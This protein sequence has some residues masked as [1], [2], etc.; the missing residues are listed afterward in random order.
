MQ[1]AG[2]FSQAFLISAPELV[3]SVRLVNEANKLMQEK[4][5]KE[6]LELQRVRRLELELYENQQM[7][8]LKCEVEQILASPWYVSFLDCLRSEGCNSN[9]T[10]SFSNFIKYFLQDPYDVLER[11]EIEYLKQSDWNKLV[12][13]IQEYTPFYN[14]GYHYILN[15]LFAFFLGCFE[16][17]DAGFYFNREYEIFLFKTKTKLVSLKSWGPEGLTFT[18]SESYTFDMAT[19][20]ISDCHDQ[21][22]LHLIT[23][24]ESDA[25][26][27]LIKDLS[28]L[29]LLL[30]QGN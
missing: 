5:L 12:N 15:Y 21:H 29:Q 14:D 13:F 1:M 24:N 11:R 10:F 20:Q 28:E 17:C 30:G 26:T 8:E 6:E 3:E 18:V 2:S 16:N 4:L 22:E 7:N 27:V 23:P 25:A 9:S 19:F